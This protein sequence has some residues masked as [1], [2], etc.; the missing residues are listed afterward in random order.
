MSILLNFLL[1]KNLRSKESFYF[2]LQIVCVCVLCEA[3]SLRIKP[4]APHMLC[5][6]TELDSPTICK[7]FLRI[8]HP[9]LKAFDLS[10][11]YK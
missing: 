6:A 10:I 9:I 4:R 5:S 3:V 7:H 2:I 8:L 11:L 1:E